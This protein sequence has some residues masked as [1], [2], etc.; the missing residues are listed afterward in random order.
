MKIIR[1]DAE[2][3]TPYL[4]TVLKNSGH[5]LVTLQDGV[6]EDILIAA[7]AD[8]DLL[9]MC[10]TAITARIIEAAPNLRGIVKY[11]VGIDAIDIPAAKARGI[12]VVNIPEYA[13]ETVAEGAFALMIALA[14]KLIP[15]D[16]KMRS[17]GWA[18]PEPTWRGNDIADKTVGI[19]GFGK[20]GRSMARM[21]GKGFRANVIAYSP[22]T[23]A[24][25]MEAAGVRCCETLHELLAQSDMV[26]IHCVLNDSTRH[27]IGEAELRAMQPHAHLINVS[28]GAIVDEVALVRALQEGWIAGAGLDVFS[29]EPLR[30]EGHMISPLYDMDNVL[31]SP[32]LTFYTAEAMERLERETLDRCTEI[33]EGRPVLVKSADPRLQ[34]QPGARYL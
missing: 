1:T 19:V 34:G 32:H 9:L 11:G 17:D 25:D 8:A 3:Q 27:L 20:I 7:I 24:A 13:E 14:R 15:L 23:P 16:R 5:D 22:H 18:W 6:D 21:C 29:D 26:S 4:D 2:L 28:R 31:L 10:Y 30:R 33:L 12:T